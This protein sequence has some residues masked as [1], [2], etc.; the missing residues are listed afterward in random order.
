MKLFL[1]LLPI[2]VILAGC[3]SFY[4]ATPRKQSITYTKP[5]HIESE[6]DISGRFIIKRPNKNDYGN[7]TWNRSGES[8]E[9]DFNSPVGQTVA[10]IIIESGNATLYAKNESYTSESLNEMMEKRLGFVLPMNYLHYWI[11]G[12]PLPNI[13]TTKQLTTGFV[14]LGWNV[15]YLQWIDSAHPEIIQCT[16]DDLVIKLLII[17]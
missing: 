13:P 15:E 17:W 5:I 4:D 3:A 2:L 14:Q 12:V 7:F 11:Q 9:L 16:K 8:E 1:K 10:K 6:F